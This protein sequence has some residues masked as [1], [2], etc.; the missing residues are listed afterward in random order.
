VD[1]QRYERLVAIMAAMAAGDRAA[2]FWLYAE[3]GGHIGAAMRRQLRRLG[4]E[5]TPPE[6]LDGMVID[7]CL[8]L[9]D[10]GAAWDPARGAQ[11]WTWAERRLLRVASAWVGQHA[12]ELDVE[13]ID[14][15]AEAPPPTAAGDEPELDVLARLARFHPGS[16]LVLDALEQVASR[17]DRAIVLEVRVQAAGGDP[18]PA[19]TV[20]R[21]H[22]VSPE[23]VRQVVCRVRWRL[24]RLAATD[25]R[26]APLTDLAMVA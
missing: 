9:F 22:G 26:F 20:A 24:A 13:R 4:V 2:A 16:A 1:E 8:A 6:D 12:D 15:S 14:R 11:P 18:S 5:A 17:R 21:R 25:H 7:A 23:V 3:F 19:L 10:C